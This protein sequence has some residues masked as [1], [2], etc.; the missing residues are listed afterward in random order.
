M[1]R[2]DLALLKRLLKRVKPYWTH[3][4]GIFLLGLLST[5]LALLTPLPLKIAIDSVLSSEPLPGFLNRMI[6]ESIIRSDG[7]LLVF[8]AVLTVVIAFLIQL[9]SLADSLLRTYTGEKLTLDFRSRL[10]R[11][12]QRLSLSFHDMIGTSDSI[13]R[14][15]YDTS[16]L[17][18]VAIDGITPF[19]TSGFTLISM[20][21]ITFRL[22]WQLALVAMG[23]SPILFII[24]SIYRRQ[25]KQRYKE[26][27]KLESNAFSVV[28][29]ALT[30]LRVVKAFG[31]EDREQ[32]RFVRRADD[33]LDARVHLT[34]A[35]EAFGLILGLTTATGTA[36][37]IYLG[38]LHV[39]TARLTLGEL[40]LVMGYLSQ[41]YGPLKIISKKVTGIQSHLASAER[42][43]ALL[44]QPQDVPEAPGAKP[45]HR[46][47][48]EVEFREV[49][50]GYKAGFPVLRDVSFKISAGTRVG[51]TGMTGAGKSTLMNLLTRFY[52]PSFGKILLDGVDLRDY[53]LA[54][55]RGQFA[56]V[57]QDTVLFSTSIFEN[58]AYA[59]PGA[60]EEEII[61]AAKAAN[62]HDF[63]LDL[64]EGYET[65]V[66]E[67]GMRLSGGERQRV[68]LARAFLKDAPILILDEPTSAID[69]KT[70]S[71]IMEAMGRLM[72]GR[73]TFMIAHRITTL[74]NCDLLF[75][76]EDGQLVDSISNVSAA[77]RHMLSL[78][79]LEVVIHEG[80]T[81]G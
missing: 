50:F 59:K 41:L 42:V 75:M 3:I 43:F 13:Y 22:D 21:Y 28:Q 62:A 38:V 69:M 68:A 54:D 80:N 47:S 55:L 5:P 52:D 60:T 36:A 44:D 70:E 77:V 48:G 17:R 74:E 49:S 34:I 81:D 29:E 67:R 35:E 31:Q 19:I 78:D 11:Q 1:Y 16:A 9:Q 73:T 2:T 14:I 4:I 8:A 65:R 25:L 56:I 20:L 63:I 53:N 37:V 18:Y 12:V 61:A 51:I 79:T 7:G 39:Q 32:E 66:G 76:L 26:V 57:L 58:I 64:P 71:G 23:V 24:A 27:K 10:F 30:A 33:T 45:I 46:A 72:E 15:Q 6:P 40:L